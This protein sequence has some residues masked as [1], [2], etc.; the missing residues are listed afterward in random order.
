M[1]S[2]NIFKSDLMKIHNVVQASMLVYPKEAII[3]ILK[4]FFSH[5]S[6][7]H[8]EK[9]EWG[10]ANT[11]DHTGMLLGSDLP[12]GAPGSTAIPNTRL[13]TRVFIGENYRYDGIYYPAILVKSGGGKY[14]PIS[15]N[16]EY[17]KVEYEHVQ[18]YDGYGNTSTIRKPM[19]FVTNGVWEGSF[20]VEVMTKSLRSRDD[21]VELVAMCFQEIHFKTLEDIGIVIKPIS[22]S[23][24]TEGDDRSDKLFRQSITLDVRTEWERKIPI[25]NIIESIL[26]TVDFENLSNKNAIPAANMTINSQ[27]NIIDSILDT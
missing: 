11:T 21:L 2:N 10:F 13:S 26:F 15:L 8:Y 1:S 20:N 12:V 17:G 23:G 16:R 7:Y 27:I 24:P 5:D 4:D 3:S 14:T 6:Y 18:Y 19:Y 22:W 25:G 9:D